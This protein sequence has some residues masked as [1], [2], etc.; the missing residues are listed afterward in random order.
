[1]ASTKTS[2][3][4]EPSSKSSDSVEEIEKEVIEA[5]EKSDD[6]HIVMH[7]VDSKP[8]LMDISWVVD[9]EVVFSS[10]NM[11]GIKKLTLDGD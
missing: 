7:Q 4:P 8:R 1:M 10:A 2:S 3:P 6:I 11:H 9:N 5:F